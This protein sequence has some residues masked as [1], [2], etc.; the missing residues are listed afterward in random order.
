MEMS[1]SFAAY[2][3]SVPPSLRIDLRDRVQQQQALKTVYEGIG[4]EVPRLLEMMP[5]AT[6]WYFDTAAQVDMPRRWQGRV[7]LVGDA[8]YCA[9]P[10][11]AQGTSRFQVQTRLTPF[12][13]AGLASVISTKLQSFAGSGAVVRL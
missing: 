7:V 11:S 1:R 3:V 13:G 10:M 12:V 8:A 6:D 4:G 9:S 2:G 5:T